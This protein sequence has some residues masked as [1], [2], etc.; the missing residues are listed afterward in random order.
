MEHAQI[1]QDT[2][3]KLG[4]GK[5]YIS[6]KRTV[7]A[8]QLALEDE[9]RLLRVKKG[10]YIP[11]AEMCDCTWSA[12]ERNI[13]MV[14][15]KAWKVNREGLVKMAGYTMSEPPTASEF[16]VIMVYHLQKKLAVA[17]HGK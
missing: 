4:V 9:D 13:R 17:S 14:V 1:I 11:A 15:E 10:I 12:V 8:I 3:R 6:Q 16:I 5:N 2:L 7:V